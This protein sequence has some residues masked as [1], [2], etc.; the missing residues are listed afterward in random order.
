MAAWR[1]R[2]AP[3]RLLPPPSKCWGFLL[4]PLQDKPEHL[5]AFPPAQGKT[6]VLEEKDGSC[7]PADL[8]RLVLKVVFWG[9]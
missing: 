2:E 9:G 4:P 7:S 3:W 8:E 6:D 1:S 5:L